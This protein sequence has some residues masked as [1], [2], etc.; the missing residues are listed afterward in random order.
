MKRILILLLVL[1]LVFCF[2]ACNKDDPTP[3][4][5][6]ET[7]PAV[8]ADLKSAYDFVHNMVKGLPE[9]TNSDYTVPGVAPVKDKTFK[10]TW[11]VSD[12][13]VVLEPSED[14]TIVTVKVIEPAEDIPYTLKFTVTNEKG[15]TLSRE[16]SHVVPKFAY[17]TFAEYAAA[18]DDESLVICGVV[19]GVFSK[20]TGSAA[21]GL[22]IQDLN[23][24]GGYYV[25]NLT[26][27][28]NGVILPG[29]T[30]KV[31]GNKD[32]Y[33]GTYELINATV[34]IVDATITPVTPVDFTELLN[35]AGALNDA[36]L[37]EKQ[38]MLVT[39]KDVTIL[40]AGDNGYYYFQAGNHKVYL[41]IS[42]SNNACATADLNAIKALHGENYG[43]LADVTGVISLYSGNFYLSPVSADAFSNVRVPERSDAEKVQAA[44]TAI[45]GIP[46][47]VSSDTVLE[48]PLSFTNLAGVTLTWTVDSTDFSFTD[49]GAKLPITLGSSAVTIKLTATAT[50]GEESATKEFTVE[51]SA[52]LVMNETHAYTAL[53]NQVNLGKTLYLDGGVSDRYLTTTENAAD[54]VAVYAEKATGG[55]K[56]YILDGETKLYIT[57]YKNDANKDSVKYDAAGETVFTYNKSVNAWVTNLAGADKYLGMYNQFNTVSVSGLTYI[58][59]ENTGVTQ[60]P[61]EI[62]PVTPDTALTMS[63]NQVTA[64]KVVYL[65]GGVSGRYLTTTENAADAIAIYAEK[66]VGGYKIYKLDGETKM[67]ITIYN[68]TEGK[69]SVN[70]DAAGTSVFNYEPSV[71]A[72]VAD[73]DGTVY[74]IGSYQSFTTISA[75]KLS[76]I[77][78]ENTGV[79]QFVLEFVA[80]AA[81]T[82]S[83]THTNTTTS[84]TDATCTVAGSTTVTCTDCGEV[85]S[86]TEIP[87]PGH[88]MSAATCVAPAT[89]SVC[90]T[91][92][93]EAAG[94]NFV[95]GTCSACGTTETHVCEF[96]A[97]ETTAP[98][99]TEDGYTTYNCTCGATE[100]RDTVP[101]T[102]HDE[103]EQVENATCAKEGA[104]KLV[105]A[106]C[107]TVISSTPIEKLPHTDATGDYKCDACSAVVEPEADSVLTLEQAQALAKLFAHNTYTANKYYVVVTINAVSNATY[108]NMDVKD[109]TVDSFTIYGTYS[110][111]GSTQYGSMSTK[112]A[113]YDIVKLYGVLGTYNNAAQMKNAWIV[114]HTVH[115]CSEYT[116]ATCY[117][118]AK[119]VVC[120]TAN[121]EALGHTTEEGTCERCGTV[122]G[123]GATDK[124]PT[125]V[126][127]SHTDIASIAGVTV[128]QNTGVIA[129]KEI[130]LND[131][132]TIVAAKGGSTSDPCIYTE[133]IRL[134]Q[135]GATIT[136]KAADGCEMT[137]IVITLAT[138]SGGQGPI[139]VTGGTASALSNNQYVI[140]VDEGVS[141]VKITTAGTDKNNRLYVANIEVN[142]EK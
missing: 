28:P 23:N 64:G 31:K 112:P 137:T 61:L 92:E 74:Y 39:V 33:N 115:E 122:V 55:Y 119:C 109:A 17:N 86:T 22:Y 47:S 48:L 1:S 103:V 59:P 14:G 77:T 141:E 3:D 81:P 110:A 126:S 70:Y 130:K 82:P 87:A 101:A 89:C 63:M 78:P 75:S 51:I 117:Q 124:V 67:Y 15:E 128:G 34:E 114:E 133:S 6:P 10:V 129:N 43:N 73:F 66:V 19:S 5:T 100:Q 65:D 58:T 54:A 125:T 135:G 49:G 56:L 132:I 80:A 102:G 72:W 140:T 91:T 138:K 121:G 108:G 93:G 16:Y 27:D 24:E 21:N 9:K 90:G 44:L 107:D 111:D 131:D 127:K 104:T 120:G 76:Y 60:F 106:N 71:N 62:L 118:P 37:V 42:S 20:S 26:D 46:S 45:T 105:C 36:A 134:Y 84:T 35:N 8:D 98:T 29:M 40:E 94:H 2:V 113:Q 7:T 57:L 99:C 139:T 96:V 116:D 50:C 4:P 88:T 83:C 32:L 123:S 13:R 53:V 30:V 52:N 25:Y 12:E 41:R 136:V 97:G 79:S 11:T 85:V 38:G 68:N 95:E 69:L 142:Y 18:A